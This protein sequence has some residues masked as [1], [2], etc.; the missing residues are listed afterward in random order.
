MDI[1]SSA[2]CERMHRQTGAFVTQGDCFEQPH[3]I[4]IGYACDTEILKKGLQAIS[5]FI[6]ME[7]KSNRR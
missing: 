1:D 5:E 6:Q 7:E 3:S 4:R 2:F